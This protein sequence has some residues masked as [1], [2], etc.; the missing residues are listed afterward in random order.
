MSGVRAWLGRFTP[1]QRFSILVAAMFLIGSTVLSIV[2]GRIIE[3]YVAQDTA[4]QTTHEIEE[5]F[6]IIFGPAIFGA[7]FSPDEQTRF[8]RTVRFHLDVY[9]IKQVWMYR[10]DG[11]VVYS[12]DPAAIGKSLF[13]G[14]DAPHARAAALG[15]PSYLVRGGNRMLLWVPVLRDGQVIGAT[16]LD[17]DVTAN[18]AAVR[19]MQGL[20]AGL[21][22]LGGVVLF[23]SLRHI[24]SDSTRLL[25]QR[26]EAE[27]SARAQVAAMEELTRLKDEFVSQVSH[28]LRTPLAPISGYAELLAERAESPEE[29]QRYARTIRRQASVLERLVDDLLE[30]A[31]LESG[32]YRLDRRPLALGPVLAEVAEEQVRDAEVHPVR[33]EIDPTLPPVD[34]DP[35]RVGQVARNLVSN[36][37]RYSPEGGE[38]RVRARREGDLVQVS[39]TDRGIGIPADRLDR[40]FEKFYRVDNELTRKVG[41]TGLGL[42][43]SRELVEAHGGRLWAESISGRGSTFYFTLPISSASVDAKSTARQPSA[44]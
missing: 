17:R 14:D 42:A 37:I 15:E 31:R 7:P 30:L 13:A 38:V 22:F 19:Q 23:F 9:D 10:P 27:R 40:V 11:Q 20:T 5:H 2:I 21:V 6:R 8:E 24:Y 4:T 32:R 41:G 16:A 35:D 29:V 36:A 18:V 26:E 33:L 43:I 3:Q 34:A 1:F 44:V 25:R 39:V 28:E 12:Y